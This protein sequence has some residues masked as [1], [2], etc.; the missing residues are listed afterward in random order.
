[1]PIFEFR[2][3]SFNSVSYPYIPFKCWGRLKF[4]L[5]LM[6]FRKNP[7]RIC[8]VFRPFFI[9]SVFQRTQFTLFYIKIIVIVSISSD[10]YIARMPYMQKASYDELLQ[11]L[12]HKLPIA[13]KRYHRS[14][15]SGTIVALEAVPSYHF[16]RYQELGFVLSMQMYLFF[17]SLPHGFTF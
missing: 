1:M 8:F 12:P 7:D 5:S 3:L 17:L 9:A 10:A 11:L 4:L 16:K 14:V 2:I 6:L 15:V 13:L